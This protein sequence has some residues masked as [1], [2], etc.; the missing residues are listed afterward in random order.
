MKKEI[1][2]IVFVLAGVFT[3]SEAWGQD[4]HVPCGS[5]GNRIELGVENG[6]RGAASN[7]KVQVVSMPEWL[8]MTVRERVFENL[9]SGK[10]ATANF[11]FAIDKSVPIGREGMVTFNV[12]TGGQQWT[13]TVRV[14]VTAPDRYEL[15]QNF[16]NPFNPE[17]KIEYT[18]P[19]QTTVR[20]IVYDML[21]QEVRT[22]VDGAQDAGYKSY[23]FDA[24]NLPSGI[25]FY[26][27]QAGN[28]LEIKKMLL[29]K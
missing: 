29:L 26:Q 20:L 15:L 6:S 17:T 18:L 4:H 24:G 28:F 22:L 10:T 21:G 16:P 13:K 27:L 25:Y 2:Y 11:E 19:K 7:V 9:L 3:C 5:R 8:Q 14:S 12:S 23:R 1:F